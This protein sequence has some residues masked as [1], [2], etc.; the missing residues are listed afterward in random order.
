MRRDSLWS[1][2][3]VTVGVMF[4]IRPIHP[5][6]G[7]SAPSWLRAGLHMSELKKGAR[8]RRGAVQLCPSGSD[9]GARSTSIEPS[10]SR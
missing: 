6:I 8:S 7:V 4:G 2:K 5:H 1:A 9:S 10:V 3:P